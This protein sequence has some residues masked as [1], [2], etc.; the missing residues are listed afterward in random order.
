MRK[1]IILIVT[2]V[3]IVCAIGCATPPMVTHIKSEPAGARIEVNESYVGEAP[4]DVTLPQAGKRHR[5][6]AHVMIRALAAEA[7]QND[8]EKHYYYHQWAPENVL[9]DMTRKSFISNQ[10]P[11]GDR[12]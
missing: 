1:G 3:P 9:F 12:K 2:I 5:L 10:Q 4:V 8:Q 7:G 6:L 11:E